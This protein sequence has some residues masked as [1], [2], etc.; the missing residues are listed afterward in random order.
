MF[1]I[2]GG[3]LGSLKISFQWTMIPCDPSKSEEHFALGLPCTT[4]AA[5]QYVHQ[6]GLARPTRTHQGCE[7]PWMKNAIQVL[8]DLQFLLRR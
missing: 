4:L 3:L 7:A 5:C 8:D 1:H 6:S 2:Y